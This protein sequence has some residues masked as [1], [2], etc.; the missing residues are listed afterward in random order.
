MAQGF[1]PEVIETLDEVYRERENSRVSRVDLSTH[2]AFGVQPTTFA[3]FAR[4]RRCQS[5]GIEPS[6]VWRR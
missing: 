6:A 5:V 1:P 3:K 4:W 2:E